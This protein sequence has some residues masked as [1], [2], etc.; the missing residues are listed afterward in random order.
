MKKLQ[1]KIF[2]VISGIL[3][4]FLVSILFIFNYQDYQREYKN[5]ESILNRMAFVSNFGNNVSKPGRVPPEKTDYNENRI[6]M[7]SLVYTILFDGNEVKQVIKHSEEEINENEIKKIAFNLNNKKINYYIGNLYFSDYSYVKQNSIMIIID[8]KNVKDVL[9]SRLLV[10]LIIFILL[11]TI[12]VLISIYLTKW[13]IE[14]IESSFEK[15]KRFIADASHELKTPLTV[16]MA[17]VDMIKVNKGNEKWINNIKTEAD[18]MNNLVCDLLDLAKLENLEKQEE[19]KKADL[20]KLVEKT[21]LP[22]ESLMFENK[23]DFTYEIESGIEYKCL[24]DK[25][26]QLI[27]I[28]VDNAIKHTKENGYIKVL[29]NKDNKNGILLS[30][31]NNGEGIKPGDEE[32]IFERFYRSDNSR[33]RKQKRYGLG[34]AIAK[35]IVEMHNGNIFVTQDDKETKFIVNFK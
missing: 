24:K 17:N 29:L 34:L 22:F 25:I 8:N 13:I 16:I 21:I 19:L 12:I 20:S 28:L 23:I 4:L 2:I 32:K 33:N 6:F 10:S 7:D 26:Q 1:T 3:S 9:Y 15:Q 27:S 35:N 14:P 5:V 31:I 11:E 18:S 30:V